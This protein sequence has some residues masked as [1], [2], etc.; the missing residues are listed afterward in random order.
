MPAER[1]FLGGR[2]VAHVVH[3]RPRIP[4]HQECRF[5]VADLSRY[6]LHLSGIEA[7]ASKTTPAGFP[8]F[9][10]TVNAA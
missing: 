2:E 1:H 4:C 10:S 7:L 6:G 5:G 3:I 8:P 9:P